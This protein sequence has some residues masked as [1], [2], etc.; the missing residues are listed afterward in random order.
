MVWTWNRKDVVLTLDLTLGKQ[1]H[2]NIAPD[3]TH[4]NTSLQ[5]R[6]KG[7]TSFIHMKCENEGVTC[8]S[9][10]ML[11][12]LI[13]ELWLLLCYAPKCHCSA[14]CGRWYRFVHPCF[15]LQIGGFQ[16]LKTKKSISVSLTLKVSTILKYEILL[17]FSFHLILNGISTNS[18][19]ASKKGEFRLW[20]E[21]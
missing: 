19:K 11:K 9:V 6:F 20:G 17:L 4:Y 8:S 12:L 18:G 7:V 21:I 15:H 1:G 10:L 16:Q 14:S 13:L 5:A 2:G 3:M